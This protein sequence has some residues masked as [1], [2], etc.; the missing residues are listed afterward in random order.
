MKKQI[1]SLIVGGVLAAGSAMGLAACG[2]K[3]NTLTVWAPNNQQTLLQE[4]IND[5]KTE[6]PDFGLEIKLGVCGENDAYAQLSKDVEASADVYGFANDQL[7]NLRKAGGVSRI[8][9]DTVTKLKQENEVNAVEA[10][11]I[12]EAG[13]DY[14]YGYPYAADNGFFMYYDKSVVSE[15]QAKTLEGVLEACKAAGKYFL[16][17]MNDQPSWYLGSFFYGAGGDYTVEYEN[18][19]V[20][21]AGCNFGEKAEGSEYSYGQIAI[22]ALNE[23]RAN[24]N[25]V[26]CNDT[27]IN[28]YLTGGKLGACVSGTWNASLMQQYLGE[29]YAA[30]KLPTYHSSLTDDDYQIVPFQGFKLMAVNGYSKHQAE[31]HQLAAYLT[32]E[33]AQTKRFDVLGIG[34]SNKAA[35]AAESVKKNV[36]LNALLSQGSFSKVQGSLPSSYWSAFDALGT[37]IY[38]GEGKLTQDSLATKLQQL[39]EALEE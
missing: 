26:T 3:D 29:N 19:V 12:T 33:K 34:P 5:F 1:I 28:T 18:S 37:D 22:T 39:I 24:K 23:L 13:T 27:I 14:Y 31:A 38:G 11:M 21:S 17:N 15:T 30:T 6:N 35:A 2:K 4:L 20:V 8:P 16:F 9:A 10:G 32:S 25:Y 7:I 36:A